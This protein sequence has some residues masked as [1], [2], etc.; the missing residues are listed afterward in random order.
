MSESGKESP[1]HL[2]IRGKPQPVRRLNRKTLAFAAG[3]VFVVVLCT[4]VWTLR[5]SHRGQGLST[6]EPHNVD[7]VS[8]PEGLDALP[9]DYSRIPKLG[10]PS[11]ELGRPVVKAEKLAGLAPLPERASFRPDPEEDAARTESLRQ[12][13]ETKEAA[14]APVFFQLNQRER[15]LLKPSSEESPAALPQNDLMEAQSSAP[16]GD[17]SAR[18]KSDRKQAFLDR[19]A[20]SVLYASGTLQVPRSA[21]ELLAGTV[22]PAALVTGIN[23]DLPGQV[24]ATVTESVYDTVTGQKTLIPQGSRLMGQYDSQIAFGQRRLLLVWT[25]LI[26][27]D[28]SSIILDR[29]PGV[30]AEGHAGLEDKVD[31]HWDRI[32]AGAAVSTLVG[33]AA[34]LATPDRTTNGSGTVVIATQQSVQDSVNQV[35]QQITR[36]NLDIQPTLSI[37]PGFV[38]R[39]IVNKDLILR[40]YPSGSAAQDLL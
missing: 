30:D 26:R 31:W 16:R 27:P 21:D 29:L 36:R 7:H 35:G 13:S 10:P 22:I 19:A 17:A 38:L 25:R 32:F 24:I 12:E 23:S 2:E 3:G 14:K 33:V 8:K 11:G 5:G 20:D 28:G 34:A 40:P 4:T 39:V 15:A 6:S 18:E 1:E 37:R 9:K